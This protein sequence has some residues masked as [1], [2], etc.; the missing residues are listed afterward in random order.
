MTEETTFQD[1]Q[2]QTLEQL[3]DGDGDGSENNR[4]DTFADTFSSLTDTFG[5]QCEKH[6]VDH[7]VVVATDGQEKPMVFSRCDLLTTAALLA[8]V[9]REMKAEIN[10]L[11]DT[12]PSNRGN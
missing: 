10:S 4:Q 2:N 11:I 3:Q 1:D 8:D 5:E 12:E 6:N 9:L 7:V